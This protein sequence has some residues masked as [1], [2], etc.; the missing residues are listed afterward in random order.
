MKFSSLW[1]SHKSKAFM[2]FMRKWLKENNSG[3]INKTANLQPI[4]NG[5]YLKLNRDHQLHAT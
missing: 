2:I 5:P 4:K 3:K 1:Q